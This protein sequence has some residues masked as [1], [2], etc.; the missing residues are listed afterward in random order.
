MS[1][2]VPSLLAGGI[3]HPTHSL[4]ANLASRGLLHIVTARA[5][6]YHVTVSD[7]L[8]RGRTQSVT[9]ARQAVMADLRALGKSLPE[10]GRY[11]DRDH[12]TVLLGIRKAHERSVAG[13]NETR[14]AV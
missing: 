9:A 2:R 6:E 3:V 14:R 1:P 13:K 11:L 7:V 10:I 8:G 12:T 5:A 4:E